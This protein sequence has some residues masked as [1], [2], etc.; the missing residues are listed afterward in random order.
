MVI[1]SVERLGE[2]TR[3]EQLFLDKQNGSIWCCSFFMEHIVYSSCFGHYSTTV[4][5]AGSGGLPVLE[6]G[7]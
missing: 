1:C 2:M 6:A 3:Q 7:G 5:I 4:V